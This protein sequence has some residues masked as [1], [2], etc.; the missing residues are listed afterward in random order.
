MVRT[1]WFDEEIPFNMA[2]EI[3][4]GK[5]ITEHSTIGLI[6]TT[7]GS[8]SDIPRDEYAQAE[9]RVVR[10]MKELEKPFVIL[11]NA[12]EPSSPSVQKLRGEM[13][14]KYGCPVQAVS[15]M[16]M[17]EKE[18]TD[19]MQQILYEFP[20]KEAEIFLPRWI[21]S[22]PTDHWLREKVFTSVR[23]AAAQIHKLRDVHQMTGKLSECERGRTSRYR[24]DRPR[25][26]F[27]AY[28]CHP[29]AGTLL[30]DCQRND[31][32]YPD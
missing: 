21:L 5:V 6:V 22:L 15:C 1:P 29:P 31:R 14:E 16:T 11:L 3:G 26:R 30:P 2:A 18:I 13:E 12:R 10:E 32:H 17:G 25:Q 19:V 23:E 24:P 20:L 8:I 28:P 9:E 7:D 4:T 27:C